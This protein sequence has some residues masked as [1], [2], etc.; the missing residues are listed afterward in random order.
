MPR[1][2]LLFGAGG[3]LGRVVGERLEADPR[4]SAVVRVASRTPGEP[5][6]GWVR[7]DLVSSPPQALAELLDLTRPDVVVSCVGRLAGSTAEL[8]AANVTATAR[9]VDG[10]LAGGQAV[11]LVVLG[12]AA[13]YGVTPRGR[14]CREDDATDP[15]GAYGITKL[16]ATSLVRCAVREHGLDAVVLRVFNPIGAGLPAE[17]VLGRAA[18][19]IR[20]ALA[21]GHQVV[22]L[23]PLGAYRDFVD[24]RDVA[25]AVAAA[26]L[27]DRAPDVVVN[28]G[29]G[30]ATLVRRAVTDLA[31]VAGY[32]G[33][34]VESAAAPSRSAAV[35]WIAADLARART[36]LHWTPSHDLTSSLKDLWAG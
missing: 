24:V 20:Q 22:Q 7:H 3:F 14:P 25:R 9:L 23:G 34:V 13:E 18:E 8:V 1:R 35:D 17:S 15:V 27:V 6:P 28:V 31:D 26:A 10:V 16:A 4:A 11:R 19:R 32:T 29:S 30:V 5:P 2:V 12:S 33:A 36:G 21:Q